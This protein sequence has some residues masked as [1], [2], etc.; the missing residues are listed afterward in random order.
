MGFRGCL[1]GHKNG[2]ASGKETVIVRTQVDGSSIKLHVSGD[3][4]GEPRHS[5]SS[6]SDTGERR[7]VLTT[8]LNKCSTRYLRPVIERQNTHAA[9]FM[10]RVCWSLIICRTLR[11]KVNKNL[12]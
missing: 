10:D 9:A 6:V 1:R 8:P 12:F 11:C 3:R 5:V 2:R 4:V 7:A